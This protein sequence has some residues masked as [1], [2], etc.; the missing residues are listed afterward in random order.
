MILTVIATIFGLSAIT[1]LLVA[2]SAPHLN[3]DGTFEAA[4]RPAIHNHHI[5]AL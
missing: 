3:E 4:S 1:F 5:S 2:R